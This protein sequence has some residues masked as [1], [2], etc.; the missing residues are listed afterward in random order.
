MGVLGHF[1]RQEFQS[2]EAVELDVFGLVH[3]THTATTEL[4]ED[5]V[6]RDGLPEEWVGF[7]HLALILGCDL[8]QV[9]EPWRRL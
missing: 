3:H 1:I 2:Y 4:F 5:A 6:M 9:N 7:R 8:G